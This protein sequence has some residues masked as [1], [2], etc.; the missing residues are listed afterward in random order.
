[1]K[2]IRFGADTAF[3]DIPPKNWIKIVQHIEELGYSTILEDDHFGTLDYD[4]IVLISAGLA[5]T[6]T[7]NFGT[8]LLCVDYRH[9]VIIARTAAALHL[10]S[11]GRFE[12]GI[13]AGW[14]LQEYHMA[15]IPYDKPMTRIRR[16][17][18]A[19]KIIKRLWT[20]EKTS[21]KGEH[22]QISEMIKAG[23]LTEGEHPKI[24]VGGGGKEL[25]KVAGRHADIVG[26]HTRNGPLHKYHH[27]EENTIHQVKK[28]IEWVKDSA[29][30]SGRDLDEIEF[31]MLFPQITISNYPA[32]I[33]KR[34]A[35]KFE[36]TVDIVR[37][38][39]QVI[40]GSVD[41]VVDKLSLIRDETDI[42]YFVFGPINLEAFD[43]LAGEVI[44]ALN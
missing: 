21:F 7:I 15:G 35:R 24:M 13:G 43:V 2:P 38:S 9:P 17:D 23:G 6:K 10:L 14:H 3:I 26:I 40:V 30:K 20:M 5:A 12:F 32:P 22:Y 36:T 1:M 19:L 16:L 33:Y 41:E 44:P 25:L 37:R 11:K 18:E 42:S 27:V 4:P 39:P 34:M 8:L 29:R 31:Q 28:R